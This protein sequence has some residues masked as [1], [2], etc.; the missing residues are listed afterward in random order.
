M[1]T[2]FFTLVLL[3]I[4]IY[5]IAQETVQEQ[6]QDSDS[7]VL[8]SIFAELPEVLV[9][10]ERPVVKA[11]EGKLVY[12]IGRLVD[13][14]GIDN[15]YDAIKELPG[16]I[17]QNEQ[18]TLAGSG[19]HV[20]INGK[21][22][23]LTSEQLINLLKSTPVSLVEKAEVLHASPARYQV[24]GPMINIIIKK[25][26]E[27]SPTL[28]GEIFSQWQQ[29]Y[30]ERLTERASL[31]FSSEK[32][33]SDLIYSYRHRRGIMTLEKEALHTA[34]NIVHPINLFE[35]TRSNGSGHDLR[36]GIDYSLYNN[37]QL[38]AVY[39]MQILDDCNKNKKWGAEESFNRKDEDNYLHNAR[40][41]YHA[42]FGLD[43]GF[44]FTFYKSEGIQ[45]LKSTFNHIDIA[46]RYD[47]QQRINKWRFYLTQEHIL[48]NNWKI[49]Y[50]GF[51]TTSTDNSYQYY[52][53]AE[54]G[55]YDPNNSMKSRKREYTINGFA[56]FAKSFNER[57][58]MD[59]SLAAELY[60][61][62]VWDEWMFYPT[63]NLTYMINP[64]RI[65]QFSFTSNKSYPSYWE[66]QNSVSYMGVYTELQGNPELKPAQKH[67][68][69]LS[70]ILYGKYIFTGFFSHTKDYFVQT[71]YQKQDEL[72]EVYKT[73]NFDYIQQAGV[74]ATIPFKV[75]NWLNTRL[76]LTGLY[77]HQKDSHFWDTSFD[78]SNFAFV[79]TMN[80][81]FTFSSKPD[82]KMNISTFYQSGA[83][84]GIY[85]LNHSLNV[86]ASLIWTFAKEKAQ[87]VLKGLDLFDSSTIDPNI[88]FENQHVTNH[89]TTSNRGIELSFRYKFGNYKEKRREEVDKSRFK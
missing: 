47:N 55:I 12:D 68:A 85:D 38:S 20:V 3:L 32:V 53:D 28:H 49:N 77:S 78:R 84:Q 41:D 50:G 82:L 71:L 59:F 39:T 36:W 87:I 33:S 40:L 62:Q 34:N 44:E 51:Y 60:H 27:A 43:A 6:E 25:D 86:D 63:L 11:E 18:L 10:G 13:N 48:K 42:G 2:L 75:Q 24:R 74:Q 88:R 73:V 89:F 70:Y 5:A 65:W 26:K 79:G 21:V 23:S 31:L 80:N 29:K 56:G 19:V 22:S 58:S 16:I 8:D 46:A 54:T 81:T 66:M 15:A 61:T 67:G 17:E 52:F 4:S 37:H 57:L 1:K 35:D 72:L 30:Y 45:N 64:A 9:I 7:F 14:M 83:I 69:T 76:T